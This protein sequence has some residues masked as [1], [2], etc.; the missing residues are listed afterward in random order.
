ME[1][2]ISLYNLSGIQNSYE[3]SNVFNLPKA[4]TNHSG[5]YLF[6]LRFLI[7]FKPKLLVYNDNYCF[8]ESVFRCTQKYILGYFQSS[9]YFE[10]YNK[11][12]IDLFQFKS[13]SSIN[14]SISNKIQKC[15]SVSIHIRRGDYLGLKRY[16]NICNEE[17]YK[18]AI[19][20]ILTNV[21]NPH[22]YVFSNDSKWS[23]VFIEQF[24]IDYT[25]IKHNE[26]DDSYQDMYLMS[27]CKH[28]IIANS[29]FSWWGAY[30]NQNN[31]AIIIA[32]KKWDN[33]DS[34]E[35]NSIRVPSNFIR[36]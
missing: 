5:L 32:P 34:D 23:S 12:I 35:Y 6:W 18:N 33:T 24:G 25:I 9:M 3:L 19:S 21:D 10:E 1:K 2:D 22:F 20:Y 11:D 13:I 27:K 28:N 26:G 30:L 17:Y 16:A 14:S 15:N 29:S 7:H 36:L 31:G 4:E 8:D